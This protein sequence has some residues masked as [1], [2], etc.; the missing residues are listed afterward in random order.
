MEHQDWTPI[1]LKKDEKK[2]IQPHPP[3]HKQYKNLDSNDPDAP[4][5]V[6]LSIGKQIQQ[7]RLNKKMTQ[8]ELAQKINVK[9]NIIRDYENGKAIPDKKVI[10]KISQILGIKISK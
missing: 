2:I 1:V 10:Q 5:P 3:G 9:P 8:D 7:A 4:K 6:G